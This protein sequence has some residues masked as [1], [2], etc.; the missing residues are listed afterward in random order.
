MKSKNKNVLIITSFCIF[1]LFLFGCGD[2]GTRVSS[3][4]SP[5]A[6][7]E[8]P[9]GG[10][11]FADPDSA[12]AQAMADF[13]R[14]IQYVQQTFGL[15]PITQEAASY[16]AYLKHTLELLPSSEELRQEGYRLEELSVVLTVY[17]NGFPLAASGE[18][19]FVAF[20]EIN[21]N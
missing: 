15:E 10:T 1:S 17:Q 18:W 3:A 20:T 12:F 7:R 2:S 8:D 13:R 9:Q 14:E 5:Y 16:S 19:N 6:T 11:V 4:P 21:S